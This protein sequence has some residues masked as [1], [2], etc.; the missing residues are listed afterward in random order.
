MRSRSFRVALTFTFALLPFVGGATLAQA[1]HRPVDVTVTPSTE[2][3]VWSGD[4]ATGA[5]V[6]Y[7]FSTGEPCTDTNGG[8]DPEYCD[9]R[10]LHVDLT[11]APDFWGPQTGG[12]EIRLDQYDPEASDFDLQ[13]FASDEHGT[14][15]RLLGSSGAS[16][17]ANESTTI[18]E[19]DGYYLIQVVYF[20]VTNGTYRGTVELFTRDRAPRDVDDP[21]G[22]QEALASDPAQGWRSRSEM[23]VAQSP[24][25]SGVLLAGSKFYNRDPDSLAEYEFKVGSYVSFDGGSS[26]DDLGQTNTCPADQAPPAS[27]PNNTC[28]PADDPGRDGTGL[29]DATA[30]PGATVN[31]APASA[32]VSPGEHIAGAEFSDSRPLTAGAVG[33]ARV[34]VADDGDGCLWTTAAASLVDSWIGVAY[35]NSSGTCPTFQNKFNAATAA[36]ADGLVVI[37]TDDSEPIEGTAVAEIP[38]V[39]VRKSD[40][41]RIAGAVALGTVKATLQIPR[42]SDFAEE[43]ITSDPWVQFDDEGNAYYM[44]LD[45]PPFESGVGW[46]MSLHRWESVSAADLQPG[47]ET[48]GNRIPINAY[49]NDFPGRDAAGVLDDKNTFAVNN[50]G[51]DGDGRTGTMVACWGQNVSAAI[52]QQIVCERSTD[53]GR[54]WPDTPT[55]ISGVH[56]LVIG[57][58][59]VADTQSPNTFYATWLQYASGIAGAP[60]TL[61]FNMSTDGG[62]TWLPQ[63]VP[64]ATISD[65]P[66]QYPRQAFRNLSIPI[67]AVGPQSELYVAIAEYLDAPEPESDLDGMQADV[68]VRKCTA[69]CA[70]SENWSEPINITDDTGGGT[71]ANA[72]QFQPYVTATEAGQVNVIYFD[73][74]HDLP[75]ETHPGNYFT[76]VY[77]SRSNDGGSTWSDVRVTH[78]ATDPEFNAPVSGSGLFFGDYQGLVAD[79]CNAIPFVNDTHLANDQ[80]LDSGPVRDPDFDDGL[81]SSPFQEAVSW[82]IPNTTE[83]G[84]TRATACEADLVVRDIVVGKTG[85]VRETQKTT[86]TATI[87]NEGGADATAS[88]T[89]FV[90]DG[91]ISLG[92]VD[93]PAIAAGGAATVSLSW[94][95]RQLQGEHTMRVTADALAAVLESDE[96]NNSAV[97]TFVVQGNKVTNGSFE[98]TN[99]SGDGPEA[100]TGNETDAGGTTW[101]NR[102]TGGS[103]AAMI[104]GRKGSV[105]LS[106]SPSWVSDPI[107]VV[108]GE[109]LDLEVSVESH[110]ASSAPSV[111][112]AYLGAA[113]DVIDRVTLITAP[114]DTSGFV[115]LAREVTI[116]AGVA[117]VKIVLTGFAPTDTSTSGTVIFDDVGLYGR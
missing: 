50:A 45:A 77:L 83:F 86:I 24:T 3:Q 69:T 42:G 82:R 28:Y 32:S 112:L 33:P 62:L 46:G 71:N 41:D 53:G 105:L 103:K 36:G 66:R 102:G 54:S 52:K 16:A 94:D 73:R 26:W 116:P 22:L 59:V 20:A 19:P 34:F 44:V 27:W 7:N 110:D 107:G 48:W 2:L 30:G 95:P 92:L 55:P 5:N 13:V 68:I 12:V 9:V 58:H 15:G 97:R 8:A 23:H 1:N 39:L 56:Q 108:A 117:E 114:L 57:V 21:P 99:A 67:M 31:E 78:D 85:Q 80:F 70:N 90:L 100:W 10:L 98:Q 35:R 93:T 4:T 17:G 75:T 88:S 47:G 106:G 115:T 29:E 109:T 79:E 81:P 76:D 25:D 6:N 40:G 84:G 104:T 101:T 87:A 74:R 18:K 60:A 72:D 43:Y 89:K 96:S 14:K 91:S 65:I 51:P 63:S 37:N 111:G 38:G 11:S 113:G 49:P 61:E 64:I